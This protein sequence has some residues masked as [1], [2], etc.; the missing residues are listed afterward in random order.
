MSKSVPE[1]IHSRAKG[2]ASEWYGAPMCKTASFIKITRLFERA[3]LEEREYIISKLKEEADLTPCSEDAMVTRSN[4][5][6][7]E[8]E[9]SYEEAERLDE[10]EGSSAALSTP[11]LQP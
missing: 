11:T 3:I 8:A 2:F 4:A 1:D 7:I 5:R 10:A 6:L 9:F